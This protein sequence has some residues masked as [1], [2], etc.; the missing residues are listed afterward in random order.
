MTPTVLKTYFKKQNPKSIV[1]QKYKN[2]DN[3]LFL[4][5]F[6]SEL[7]DLLPNDKNLKGFQDSCLQIL[8]SLIP[9]K[10]K[11]VEYVQNK[12]LQKA[13]MIRSKIRNNKTKSNKKT[14]CKQRNTCVNMQN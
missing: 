4:E 8:N 12:E 11:Y 3:F 5:E 10:T 9:L 2:Y 1:Y 6:I 7:K 14:Y 13:I